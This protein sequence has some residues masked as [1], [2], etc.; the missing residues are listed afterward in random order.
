MPGPDMEV[1]KI[2]ETIAFCAVD[3]PRNQ[4]PDS[5]GALFTTQFHEIV[6]FFIAPGINN[7]YA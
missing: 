1:P 4:D 5:V 6:R 2:F 7:R 3:R